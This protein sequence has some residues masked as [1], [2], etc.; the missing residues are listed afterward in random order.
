MQTVVDM[1]VSFGGTGGLVKAT[2]TVSPGD[3]IRSIIG[4]AGKL[5]NSRGGGGGGTGV[6]NCGGLGSAGCDVVGKL[7]LVAGG[8]GGIGANLPGQDGKGAVTAKG[9]GNGG[10]GLASGGG[11]GINSAGGMG[12]CPRCTGGEQ[13]SFVK[14]SRGFEDWGVGDGFGG[15]GTEQQQKRAGGGGGG[16]SGG[17]G[18]N[19]DT[20]R[21]WRF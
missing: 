21:P 8:G 18:V 14:I 4:A 7:L 13:A 10:I 17:D 19:D 9:D 6:I 2:F 3:T 15:G 20:W 1:N 5:Q 11:G 16:Y 12:A